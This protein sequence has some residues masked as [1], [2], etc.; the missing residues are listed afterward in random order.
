MSGESSERVRYGT[1]EEYQ[2]MHRLRRELIADMHREG[3]RV[4]D[5]AALL[6]VTP[7][8]IRFRLP[9]LPEGVVSKATGA[10]IVHLPGGVIRHVHDWED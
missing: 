10:R 3:L 9:K 6:A 7:K 1:W 8:A 2:A 5:I 4:A